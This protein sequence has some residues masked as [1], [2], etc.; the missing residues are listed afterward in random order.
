[1]TRI[2][3]AAWREKAALSDGRKVDLRLLRPDDAPLLALGFEK[4]SD[5]SRVRRFH[6]PRP[7][8]SADEL[9]YLTQIDGENHFALGALDAAGE[10]VGVAR[11]V[12]LPS[13]TRS[14]ARDSGGCSFSVSAPR[15][16]N[17]ESTGS[18]VRS[19]RTTSPCATW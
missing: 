14:K 16:G 4:L 6:G 18:A 10:G 9:R 19:S 2:F 17:A 5:E 12:P 13:S 11:F 3:D 15:P 8:L 7:H 1:M